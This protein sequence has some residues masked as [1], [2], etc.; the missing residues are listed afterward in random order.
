MGI[1][2][3][4]SIKARLGKILNYKGKNLAKI[5]INRALLKYVLGDRGAR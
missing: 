3:R 2:L 1:R 5:I 4:S